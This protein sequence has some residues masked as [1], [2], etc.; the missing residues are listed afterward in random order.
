[1]ADA[2]PRHRQTVADL[3]EEDGTVLE[4][5]RSYI[6][7]IDDLL[8]LDDT[9]EWTWANQA[10]EKGLY[11]CGPRVRVRRSFLGSTKAE[12]D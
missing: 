12:L 1:M 6:Q 5:D 8:C 9:S 4:N 3:F 10:I 7:H 11:A 2:M